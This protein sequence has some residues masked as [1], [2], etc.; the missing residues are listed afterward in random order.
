MTTF[1]TT[2]PSGSAEAVTDELVRARTPRKLSHI[3]Y[4]TP[5]AKATADFYTRVM[6]MEMV[7]G[8][9]D[10]SIPSTG[11]EIPYFHV[12]FRMADGSTVAFFE[13]PGVPERS[14]V[15][16]PAYHIFDHLALEV[17]TTAE[18]DAW[19][20]ELESEGIEVI[21]PT[22][23]G[24]IY[25]IYFRDPINDIRLEITAPEDPDWN[26]RPDVAAD[27]MRSWVE[28]KQHAQAEGRDVAQ[29]LIDTIRARR[30]VLPSDPVLYTDPL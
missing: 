1:E 3:A 29:T 19:K 22:D 8:V 27:G 21:G 24:I 20:V 6:K 12:F 5:D 16:H 14:P 18:V 9:M 2:S 13:A 30:R 17:P 7:N 23:H 26:N 25:S 28:A 4:A 11:D 10:D 15:S